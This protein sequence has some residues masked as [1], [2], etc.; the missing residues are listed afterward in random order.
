MTDKR[1]SI[2]ELF[3]KGLNKQLEVKDIDTYEL[4]QVLD[5]IYSYMPIGSD[6]RTKLKQEVKQNGTN[7]TNRV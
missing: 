4:Q 1:I 7:H 2:N 3:D 5:A 6:N